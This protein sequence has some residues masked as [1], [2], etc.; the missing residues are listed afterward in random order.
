MQCPLCGAAELIC[1]TRDLPYT[2]QGETRVMPAVTGS[3]VRLARSL[4]SLL[5][6]L[7]G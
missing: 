5:V 1:K 4:S 3:F 6:S 7:S 2:Y